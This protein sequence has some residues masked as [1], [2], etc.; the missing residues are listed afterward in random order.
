MFFTLPSSGDMPSETVYRI[1]DSVGQVRVE[2][3][4]G[5]RYFGTGFA[6]SSRHILTNSH[7]VLDGLAAVAPKVSITLNNRVFNHLKIVTVSLYHDLA[8]LE[9]DHFDEIPNFITI[10]D[11]KEKDTRSM[12]K[13]SS[14]GFPATDI[15]TRISGVYLTAEYPMSFGQKMDAI[16][17]KGFH[18]GISGGP[19]YSN[20]GEFIGMNAMKNTEKNIYACTGKPVMALIVPA[21]EVKQFLRDGLNYS[22]IENGNIYTNLNSQFPFEDGVYFT[23]GVL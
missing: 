5:F 17:A 22:G 8:L 7:V 3:I 10:S 18:H 4:G 9:V 21:K 19:V 20:S 12:A 6:I 23:S 13:V 16:S 14:F 15:L 11:K 1:A 2:S